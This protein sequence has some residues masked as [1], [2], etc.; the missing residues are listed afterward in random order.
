MAQRTANLSTTQAAAQSP[1]RSFSLSPRTRGIII[2][3][4]FMQIFLLIVLAL[5]LFPV[6][7]VISMAVDPRG[8]T[9]PTDLNLLPPNA[10]LDAF[11]SLLS[12]PFSNVSQVYFGELIMNSLFIAL[13]TSLFTVVLGASAAYAFSRFKFIGRQA[14]MLGF[15]ILLL[16]PTTGT[17]IPLYILFSSFQINVVVANA[18]PAFFGG[19]L[20]AAVILI[21]MGM[22]RNFAKTN[23]ERLFNP[24]PRPVVVVTA[25][26]ALVAIVAAFFV[27]YERSVLYDQT[28]K[29]PLLAVRE[30]FEIAEE[31]YSLAVRG[32]Q[33][34]EGIA[35]S[36]TDR[37]A[38]AAVTADVLAGVR[39]EAVGAAD[40]DVYLTE[41]I[42][43]QYAES[44]LAVSAP[45]DDTVLQALLLAQTTLAADSPEA[46]RL[47]LT[48]A[49]TATQTDATERQ[50]D[51]ETRLAGVE[52]RFAEL[53][54]LEQ[55]LNDTRASFINDSAS[56]Y[57]QRD[58]VF[59]AALPY[60]LL[61]WGGA[62]VGAGAVWGAIYVLRNAIDPKTM[63]S[64]LTFALLTALVIG[65]GVTDLQSRLAGQD[66]N[67]TQTL[68]QTL[69]GL[70]LAF[71]SGGLPFAIWNLKGYFDTIP[72][73]LE[74]AALIDGAGLVGTF[75]R[76]M[77]PLALP[78]FAIVILFSFMAGWT[79]F[80]LSWAF[81]IGQQQDYTLAMMLASLANGANQPPPD[82]QK[83]AAMAILISA[84]IMILFFAFQR[85]IVGGLAIGGVKG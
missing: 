6:L 43:R 66:L 2:R 57:Q 12:E 58:Q 9:R 59:W 47:A 19:L 15:I 50:A 37:A 48:D 84:P 7:W 56:T 10:T 69:L 26:M 67:A 36:R 23:P 68:R 18:A 40:L 41:R 44:P 39:D 65:L 27:M 55:T 32:A 82:M 13:G 51:A 14:G 61:A 76:I 63:I 3:Q 75:I 62:L 5:V 85:W 70:A 73:E 74:E 22:I 11:T 31:A 21:V 52:G 81:L 25:I 20:V 72:K 77:I 30:P 42:A 4:I 64:V 24:G 34:A 8:V 80:I 83:F 35:I 60:M 38:A 1:D 45:E 71:A 78:A 46:A 28:V 54:G 29:A 49:A 33:Q 16:L 79:E 17:L 53:V